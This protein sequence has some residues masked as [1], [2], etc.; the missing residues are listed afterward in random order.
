[1]DTASFY[2]RLLPDPA[3][4]FSS[5]EDRQIFQE[6]LALGGLAGYFPL[7]EQFHTQADPAFCGLGTLVILAQ[8]PFD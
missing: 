7:A 6:A 5:I 8:C 1:M 3:I 4:A 2:R